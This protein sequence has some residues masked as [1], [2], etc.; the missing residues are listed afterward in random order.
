LPFAN[1]SFDCV[2]ASWVLEHLAAPQAVFAEVAR[3]LRPGGRFVFLTPNVR[4]PLPRLARRLAR[5][6]ALQARL[7][8]R[9]YGRTAAD[10]FPVYYRANSPEA[11]TQIAA[12]VGL[13]LVQLELVEDPAYFVWHNAV[14]PFAMWLEFVLPPLW[15]V[16]LI[17]D[18]CRQ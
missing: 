5:A 16:H 8:A 14:L 2:V 10:T 4:H 9:V 18:Y 12:Q 13:A 17:G 15:K 3:V 7:V 1:A 11:L 6:T